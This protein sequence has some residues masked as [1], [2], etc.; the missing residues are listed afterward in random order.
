MGITK[1]QL[2]EED[3]LCRPC[4]VVDTGAP[5]PLTIDTLIAVTEANPAILK[6]VPKHARIPLAK[7]LN[8]ALGRIV[9]KPHD[10]SCWVS[11]FLQFCAIM[12]QPERSR[13]KQ[14]S[15]LEG[16]ICGRINKGPAL[17]NLVVPRELK[18][19]KLEQDCEKRIKLISANLD[20]GNVRAGIRLAVSNDT[21]A[22][23]DNNTYKKLQSKHPPRAANHAQ[24]VVEDSLIVFEPTVPKAINSFPSG[25]SG[26]P[27][28]LV[29]QLYKD[30]IAKSN[31][32][33]GNEFLQNL[34]SVLNI[35]LEGKIPVV[36]RPFFSVLN[37]SAFGKKDGGVR[38]IA[39]GNTLRRMCSKCVSSFATDQRRIEFHG[40]SA[41]DKS[42]SRNRSTFYEISLRTRRILK[43]LF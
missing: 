6:R 18:D 10:E 12:K 31:G 36:L 42:W 25:S 4:Q 33:I 13:K 29:P 30:L 15:D 16:I 39:V 24:Q 37:L 28:L 17:G 14:K 2:E 34:T 19:S 3:F 41:A 20:D 1:K 26:G 8:E 23:F 21:V 35:V 9:A 27:S 5:L 32:P 38:P 11:F 40:S 22:P 43:T 7:L